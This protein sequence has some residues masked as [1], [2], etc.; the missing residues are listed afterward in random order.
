MYGCHP[1]VIVAQIHRFLKAKTTSFTNS[2]FDFEIKS[3]VS[4][5]MA[6]NSS[7]YVDCI[8]HM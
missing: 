4:S 5:D 6:H 3:L 7:G 8:T 1:T 2:K